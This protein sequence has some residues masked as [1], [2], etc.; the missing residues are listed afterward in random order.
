MIFPHFK[1]FLIL[2][3]NTVLKRTHNEDTVRQYNWK[4]HVTL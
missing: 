4:A 3:S 2:S 1:K